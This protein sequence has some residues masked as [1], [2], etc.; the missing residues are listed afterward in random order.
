MRKIK[1]I[2][3]VNNHT[4]SNNGIDKLNDLLSQGWEVVSVE[5][6]TGT[7]GSECS[8]YLLERFNDQYVSSGPD[9]LHVN[10]LIN[11]SINEVC[12]NIDKEAKKFSDDLN[13]YPAYL[14][15]KITKFHPIPFFTHE[16][17]LPK[18]IFKENVE[19]MS[20]DNKSIYDALVEFFD[21]NITE[22]SYTS[23]GGCEKDVYEIEDKDDFINNLFA[24]AMRI[25]NKKL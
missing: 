5:K 15:K 24:F 12:D 11:D 3:R 13:F 4:Y 17:Y 16:H 23:Y 7:D 9:R 18:D 21:K 19:K 8:D 22:T 2:V 1:K 10:Q 25:K 14:L 20:P 6:L